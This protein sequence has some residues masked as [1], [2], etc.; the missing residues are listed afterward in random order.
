MCKTSLSV[1][2]SI[3][4]AA[5]KRAVGAKGGDNDLSLEDF[6]DMPV[7]SWHGLT[8]IL[9]NRFSQVRCYWCMTTSI[10]RRSFEMCREQ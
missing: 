1:V 3:R 10:Q 4:G 6:A 7:Y 5:K 9:A 8:R 2:H